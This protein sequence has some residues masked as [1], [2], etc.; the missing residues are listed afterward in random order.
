MDMVLLQEC[1]SNTK[2][3]QSKVEEFWRLE[4][5]GVEESAFY[6]QKDMVTVGRKIKINHKPCNGPNV[7][8]NHLKFV[9]SSS[10]LDCSSR[11][12]WRK[13]TWS[14]RDLGTVAGSYLNG[15]KIVPRTS[16]SLNCGDIIG[17]GCPLSYSVKKKDFESFVYRIHAPEMVEIKK[18]FEEDDEMPLIITNIESCQDDVH[19]EVAVM[20]NVGMQLKDEIDIEVKSKD[21]KKKEKKDKKR[22]QEKMRSDMQSSLKTSSISEKECSYENGN[23][24]SCSLRASDLVDGL[25]ILRRIG[26]YF[27]PGR[28]VDISPPDIYGIVVDKERGNKPHIFSQEEVLQ[29]AVMEIKPTSVSELKVGD[30]VCAFWSRKMSYLHPGAV[31]GFDGDEN[32]A[33]IQ[34]DD[35][36]SRDIHIDQIRYLPQNYPLIVPEQVSFTGLFGSRK[37]VSSTV[38]KKLKTEETV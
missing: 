18:E 3:M 10:T 24:S 35:G 20:H 21:E 8:R 6:L 34:L 1:Q 28:L 12:D 17:V 2:M 30:R 33:I 38:M 31:A 13:V 7:S 25:R 11:L 9:R 22:R 19:E 5:V 27:C 14:V 23:H 15:V 16:Y 36:D 32:F 37:R 26:D 4:R 29:E